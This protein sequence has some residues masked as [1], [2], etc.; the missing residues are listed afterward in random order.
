MKIKLSA[1]DGIKYNACD[2]PGH[3]RGDMGKGKPKTSRL[4][5]VYAIETVNGIKYAR[6]QSRCA[7]GNIYDELFPL[8][9]LEPYTPK[10]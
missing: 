3:E 1:F 2:A 10:K 6:C 4:Y 5:S 8:K 9:T 7:W